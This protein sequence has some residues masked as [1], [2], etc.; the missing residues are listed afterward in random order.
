MILKQRNLRVAIANQW[1]R[2]GLPF[3]LAVLIVVFSGL[4]ESFR[5]VYNLV[6][7]F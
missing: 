1:D 3:L 5:T 7:N 6:S 2:F 4:S